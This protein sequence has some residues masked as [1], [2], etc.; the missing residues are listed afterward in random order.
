MTVSA[1]RMVRQEHVGVAFTGEGAQLY[2]GRWNSPGVSMVYTAG[3]ISQPIRRVFGTVVFRAREDVR[4]PAPGDSSPARW[5]VRMRDIPWDTLYSP[6]ARLVGFVA[7]RLNA[8]Q[9]L[10][11]RGYL[12]LVFGALVTLLTVLA[13]WQ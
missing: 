13:V 9:F 3:S 6:I 10:T 4:M 7:E 12:T 1:W 8:L 11:I 2:P 5:Q